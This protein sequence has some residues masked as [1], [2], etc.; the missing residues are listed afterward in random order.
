M[1]D[2]DN[3]PLPENI[4]KV[5]DAFRHLYTLLSCLRGP[6]GCPW[7]REQTIESMKKNLV[8]ESYEY[9]DAHD[10]GTNHDMKEELGDVFLVAT[11]ISIIHHESGQF[12]PD[13]IFMNTYEKLIRRHP[14]VFTEESVQHAAEVLSLWDTV[15]EQERATSTKHH[16]N[17]F[18]KIPSV[19]PTLLQTREIQKIVRGYGF[20]WN[21]TE[22]VI[23]KTIEELQELKHE[24]KGLDDEGSTESIK[25]EFGDVLFSLVNLSRFLKVDA[26]IALRSANSKFIDRFLLMQDLMQRSSVVLSKETP[27]QVMDTYWEQAK[28]ML[29]KD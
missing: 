11:M 17:I 23:D 12:S 28:S 3:M 4:E 27:L 26:D 7:D 2:S 18:E 24:I 10:N 29:E 20:D 22:D 5:T 25:E 1:I 21:K 8:E 9:I 16:T 19:M 6:E 15:K 13:E 14:H